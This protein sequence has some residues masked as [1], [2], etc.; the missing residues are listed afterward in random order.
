MCSP[1]SHVMD[2]VCLIRLE[3]L[4]NED[5]NMFEIF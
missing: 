3:T 4:I 2:G 1:I 5:R